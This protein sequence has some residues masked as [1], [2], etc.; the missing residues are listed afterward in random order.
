M[1]YWVDF[2]TCR[3]N[4]LNSDKVMETDQEGFPF[5]SWDVLELV[6]LLYS[7][8]CCVAKEQTRARVCHRLRGKGPT[9][10]DFHADWGYS[11]GVNVIAGNTT[12]EEKRF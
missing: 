11:W 8:K 6:D 7:N 5:I 10:C 1:W 3:T 9:L 2:N 12:A 4:D